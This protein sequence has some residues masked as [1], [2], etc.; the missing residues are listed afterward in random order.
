MRQR[1]GDDVS[2][3]RRKRRASGGPREERKR[4][5]VLFSVINSRERSLLED[6]LK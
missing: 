3:A 2:K 5:A 6:L 1:E 4:G